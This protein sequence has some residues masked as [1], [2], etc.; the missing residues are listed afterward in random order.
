MGVR[1]GCKL[2]PLLFICVLTV[3]TQ[4]AAQ[5]TLETHP[6]DNSCSVSEVGGKIEKKRRAPTGKSVSV[7]SPCRAGEA[8]LH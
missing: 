7:S 8:K 3:V 6:L 2:P 1:Q 5:R 4:T